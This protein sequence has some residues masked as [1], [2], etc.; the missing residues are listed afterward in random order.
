MV[1]VDVILALGRIW[2][3]LRKVT[4]VDATERKR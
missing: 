4:L 1:I 2:L 3:A